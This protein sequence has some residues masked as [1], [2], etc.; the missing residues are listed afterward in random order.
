VAS[1]PHKLVTV[2]REEFPQRSDI[3]S[4]PDAILFL[5]FGHKKDQKRRKTPGDKKHLSE[6]TGEHFRGLICGFGERFNM[7]E[8]AV[9][10]TWDGM[11][12]EHLHEKFDWFDW[13]QPP[14][15]SSSPSV[16]I[17][18]CFRPSLP[19]RVLEF[20]TLMQLCVAAMQEGLL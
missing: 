15:P 20:K 12:W 7:G 1:I 2:F 11:Y 16:S 18:H 8:N 3:S 10:A 19:R 4:L 14:K 17:S 9:N 13:P 6:L 5:H